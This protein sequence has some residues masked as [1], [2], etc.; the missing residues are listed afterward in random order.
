MRED[1]FILKK[2]RKRFSYGVMNK[3]TKEITEVVSSADIQKYN[4]NDRVK[5]AISGDSKI[6]ISKGTHSLFW[7]DNG[8]LYGA[9]GIENAVLEINKQCLLI[10]T[11]TVV[12]ISRGLI[13]ALDEK[14]N[15]VSYRQLG[16]NNARTRSVL[17]GQGRVNSNI[18]TFKE[19]PVN[20]DL[21]YD[22][23]SGIKGK[24]AKKFK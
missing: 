1:T 16:L 24:P 22:G 18:A 4:N 21:E 15:V 2:T 9:E 10:K 7:M 5:E 17:V 14:G 12:N 19:L 20:I 23:H 11:Y 6:G 13:T 3:Q 8:S